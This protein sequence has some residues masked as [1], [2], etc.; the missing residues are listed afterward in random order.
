MMSVKIES[1]EN[2]NSRGEGEEGNE[3]TT[4][5]K[6]TCSR[7]NTTT[8]P[9]PLIT[10]GLQE[11]F[12]ATTLLATVQCLRATRGVGRMTQTL[13]GKQK[14]RKFWFKLS[15]ETESTR[16]GTLRGCRGPGSCSYVSKSLLSPLLLSALGLN[17]V[18]CPN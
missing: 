5:L 7:P 17:H 13:P 8:Q 18:S 16:S 10:P 2:E 15:S 1:W 12:K 6:A 4:D 14:R 9:S 3:I 11:A